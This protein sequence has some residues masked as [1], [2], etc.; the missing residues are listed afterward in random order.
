[1]RNG[2]GH[3]TRSSSLAESANINFNPTRIERAPNLRTCCPTLALRVRAVVEEVLH[4]T[5]HGAAQH[6]I[7]CKIVS[8][9]STQ[10][11]DQPP[12]VSASVVDITST[13]RG[14]MNEKTP[15]SS[16]KKLPSYDAE[17]VGGHDSA[18]VE[19]GFNHRRTAREVVNPFENET[20]STRPRWWM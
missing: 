14:V 5:S 17:M 7:I 18:A 15:I 3:P 6:T 11:C 13:Q 20:L 2:R 12:T 16:P 19:S 4:C 9:P 10:R 1:M 8:S